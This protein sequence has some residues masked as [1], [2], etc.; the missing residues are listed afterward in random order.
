MSNAERLTLAIKGFKNVKVYGE[1]TV[2]AI[3]YK[4]NSATWLCYP[5]AGLK[6]IIL[7]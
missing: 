1:I 3:A 7:M 4:R 5:L 6:C 2:G